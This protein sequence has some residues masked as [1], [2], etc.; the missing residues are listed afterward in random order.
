MQFHL[1]S[2]VFIA[3]S[4]QQS[5]LTVASPLFNRDSGGLPTRNIFQFPTGTWIE[6]I[7]VRSNGDLLLT[8]FDTPELFILDPTAANATA[9]LVY[10][11]PEAVSLTGIAETSPD[12]FAIAVGNF[13]FTSGAQAGS[14]SI[15]TVDF[16]NSSGSSVSPKISKATDLSQAVLLDGMSSL[17]NDTILVGDIDAGVIYGVNIETGLSYVASTDPALAPVLDPTFGNVGVNGIHVR[18][19]F[20]YFVTSG[21]NV[22]G[23]FPIRAD[24]AQIGN[25]SIIA[26]ALN[27]SEV[28]DDF[29]FD[30]KGNFFIATGGGN[31]IEKVTPNGKNQ[32]IAGSL[33]STAIAEPTAAQFG[34]GKTDRHVL[35]VTTGGGL[36]IKVQPGNQTV[37]A[38]VV[39]IDM[40]K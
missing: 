4:I 22:L 25:A 32:I 24:G 30:K 21:T 10:T 20:L 2:L 37:G 29:V 35:Y 19:N 18:E 11:F 31:S 38:Q 39:A 33:N 1:Y 27:S 17:S 3:V 26:R 9:K 5:C 28:F 8:R 40:G 13:S 6:N 12:K 36:A 16:G 7:A 14:W 15:W 34:R 23:R